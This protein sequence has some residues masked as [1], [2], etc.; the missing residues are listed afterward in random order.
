MEFILDSVADRA[1][2]GPAG[3]PGDGILE[4]VPKSPGCARRRAAWAD[5]GHS[6]ACFF[7]RPKLTTRPG[8]GRAVRLCHEYGSK[9][10]T[11]RASVLSEERVHIP[12]MI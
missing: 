8:V 2:R 1:K 5:A 7:R 12:D 10:V 4:R 3:C 9:F 11:L 6:A